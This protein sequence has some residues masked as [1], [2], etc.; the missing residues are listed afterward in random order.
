MYGFNDYG[1]IERKKRPTA[2]KKFIQSHKLKQS[3]IN[4][5]IEDV[6]CDTEFPELRKN[7]WDWLMSRYVPTHT[8][9][10]PIRLYRGT[11]QLNTRM[12]SWTTSLGVA[13]WFAHRNYEHLAMAF[14]EQMPDTPPPPSI[15][16]EGVI[17]PNGIL[18][19][20]N[21]RKEQEVV[22]N[23]ADEWLESPTTIEE[24]K[25]GLAGLKN[26]NSKGDK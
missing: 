18:F 9:N 17:K 25:S 24:I 10:K 21:A 26:N 2:L 19:V 22:I 1:L 13:K 12:W 6:W 20:C 7:T 11:T 8:I 5:L 16:L 4:E 3:M 23:G 14:A 15:I